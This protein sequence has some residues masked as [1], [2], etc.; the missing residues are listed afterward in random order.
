MTS[1][2]ECKAA[3][4]QQIAARPATVAAVKKEEPAPE[5]LDPRQMTLDSMEALQKVNDCM[6]TIGNGR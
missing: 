2:E 1:L 3:V 6:H 4:R 5:E